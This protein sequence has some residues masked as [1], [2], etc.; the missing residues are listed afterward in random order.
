VPTF[1]KNT[2][3]PYSL[4]KMEVPGFF[5]QTFVPIYQT[6]RRHGTDVCDINTHRCENLKSQKQS[7]REGKENDNGKKERKN[8]VTRQRRD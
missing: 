4:L 2:M 8:K 1:W 6:R 7:N 5:P 3:F